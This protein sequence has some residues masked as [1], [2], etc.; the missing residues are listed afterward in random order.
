[1]F[2]LGEIYLEAGDTLTV[3]LEVE[4]DLGIRYRCRD[5]VTWMLDEEGNSSSSKSAGNLSVDE[6]FYDPLYVEE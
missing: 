4:D 1:M 6:R 3:D 5:M 2:D